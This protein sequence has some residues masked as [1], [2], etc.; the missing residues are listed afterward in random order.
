[1]DDDRQLD[2]NSSGR[3]LDLESGSPTNKASQLQTDGNPNQTAQDVIPVENPNHQV[4]HQHNKNETLFA[5]IARIKSDFLQWSPFNVLFF[6]FAT[7]YQNFVALWGVATLGGAEEPVPQGSASPSTDETNHKKMIEEEIHKA[8]GKFKLEFASFA[9]MLGCSEFLCMMFFPK[10]S[11][12]ENILKAISILGFLVIITAF[13]LLIHTSFMLAR[14]N[15]FPRAIH[16]TISKGL[17][18]IS[19]MA[20]LSSLI[21]LLMQLPS[22][23]NLLIPIVLAVV[24][25]MY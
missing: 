16:E 23:Y 15:T 3:D 1:M 12:N 9:L 11:A 4:Q 10:N 2:E 17:L 18:I 21:P 7:V 19:C 6:L 24:H 14:S 8:K 20:L 5:R 25:P 22:P 13:C